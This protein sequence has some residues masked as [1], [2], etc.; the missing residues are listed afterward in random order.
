MLRLFTLLCV[1]LS[2]VPAGAG[3]TVARIKKDGIVR[4]GTRTVPA[5]YVYV[6]DKETKGVD[7]E[8]CSAVATAI[9]GRPEAYTMINVPDGIKA[10]FDGRVDLL[11]GGT[12]WTPLR[13]FAADVTMPETLYHSGFSFI[14]KY[15]PD[16]TSMR[17]YAGSRVCVEQ[18]PFAVKALEDYNRRFSLDFRIMG[19]PS[20]VRAKELLY[21]GR[22]DLVFEAREV[23]HSEY[24]KKAPEKIDLV[25]LP[26]IVHPYTTGPIVL[27]S[28][29]EF[30]KILRRL[31]QGLVKAEEKGVTAQNVEDFQSTDDPEIRALLAEDKNS[32]LKNGVDPKWLY[33]TI[34][35]KGNYGEIFSRSMGDKSMLKMNRAMNKLTRDGGKISAPSFEE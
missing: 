17:S 13:E 16:A 34:A 30:K 7:A 14:G 23:L 35:E 28:D 25:V 15:N 10:L 22:C 29:V 20:L 19:L 31:I 1:L 5:A 24:F 2:A 11:L 27:E 32:A 6:E 3:E 4:C 21:I 8:F 18:R 33:R 12:P 26:E 9:T